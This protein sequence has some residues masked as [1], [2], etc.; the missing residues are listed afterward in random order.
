MSKSNEVHRHVRLEFSVDSDRYVPTSVMAKGGIPQ[1]MVT[2]KQHAFSYIRWNKG[3]SFYVPQTS[4]ERHADLCYFSKPYLDAIGALLDAN[5]FLSLEELR[6]QLRRRQSQPGIV[7]VAQVTLNA[8]KTLEEH[9]SSNDGRVNARNFVYQL[10]VPRRPGEMPTERIGES[11]IGVF[12]AMLTTEGYGTDGEDK[13][14][15]QTYSKQRQDE[16]LAVL[17]AT[18]RPR[19][20]GGGRESYS[21][22]GVGHVFGSHY[23]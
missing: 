1:S 6:A 7:C 5:T 10:M 3:G 11:H 2:G 8:V 20:S 17:G 16:I 22:D 12:V 23:D 18:L 14:G 19:Q 13:Q 15:Q 21:T 4:L 9:C